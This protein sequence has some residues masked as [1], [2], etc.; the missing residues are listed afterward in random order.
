MSPLP[1]TLTGPIG[2]R[3]SLG[4]VVLQADEVI[5][6]DFRRLFRDPEIA[7]YV[8]R[9]PSGADLTGATLAAME[10]AL[11]RAAGLLPP[12][13]AFAAIG[14]ACTSG[15]TV[16]GPPRVAALVRGA[17]RV[18]AVTDPLS[19]AIAAFQALGVRRIGLISPY[20]AEVSGALCAALEAAGFTIAG[21]ASFEEPVEARVAR[22]APGS[23]RAAALDIGSLPEVEAVFL[24]CT[25]LRTLDSI[26]GL[27]RELAK[28]VVSSNLA[29]AWQMA[30]LAGVA[31][32]DPAWG[33][34]PR[35]P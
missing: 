11:P 31:P 32:L 2:S 3:A 17:A 12:T 9:I 5:E 30:R 27:E 20:I 26:A 4:L 6:Q 25:N 21:F 24:S 16:I 14:Y 10:A 7:L 13:V 33:R 19:A 28:P 34:L 23:I 22:I 1:Y 18:E 8:T 35:L 29:L 15:A